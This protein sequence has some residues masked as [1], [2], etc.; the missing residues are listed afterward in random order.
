MEERARRRGRKKSPA[1]TETDD[2]DGQ[3]TRL[4]GERGEWKIENARRWAARERGSDRRSEGRRGK[5]RLDGGPGNM[6]RDGGSK[7]KRRNKRQS[8][9]YVKG[10]GDPALR[11]D[12]RRCWLSECNRDEP[13]NKERRMHPRSH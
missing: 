12:D 6:K 4:A 9:V 2:S 10:D 5:A 11:G 13:R 3:E 8:P 1:K 7:V